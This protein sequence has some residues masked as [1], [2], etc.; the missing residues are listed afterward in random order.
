MG[1]VGKSSQYMLFVLGILQDELNKKVTA[2][3]LKVK[4]PKYVFIDIVMKTQMAKTKSRMIY[5][6][7]QQ[8]EQLRLVKYIE[9]DLILT[10]KGKTLFKKIHNE[11][12]P[13]ASLLH[14]LDTHDIGKFS[15]KS[16]TQFA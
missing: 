7:L 9:K 15:K 11:H 10:K 4:L 8:L 13:Y 2:S 14:F 1:I 16:Q 5:K 6:N 12:I 3:R